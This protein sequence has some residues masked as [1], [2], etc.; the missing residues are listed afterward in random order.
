M[1]AAGFCDNSVHIKETTRRHIRAS[2]HLSSHSASRKPQIS[3]SYEPLDRVKYKKTQTEMERR[4]LWAAN[5][6]LLKDEFRNILGR[7]EATLLASLRQKIQLSAAWAPNVPND[8]LLFS[9]FR[10][11]KCRDN[12]LRQAINYLF[13]ILFK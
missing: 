2:S 11:G 13:H 1:R 10:P 7:Q 6:P 8:I 3:H 5:P 9:S 12:T 4:F